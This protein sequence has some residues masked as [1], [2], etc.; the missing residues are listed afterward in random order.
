M[1][2]PL[3]SKTN[4]WT[5]IG[6]NIDLSKMI[7]YLI[8]LIVVLSGGIWWVIS[9]IN[10]NSITQYQVSILSQRMDK[11]EQ[12]GTEQKVILATYGEMLKH[13]QDD[14][15]DWRSSKGK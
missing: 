6:E 14:V 11:V 3:P 15:H 5:L 2:T 8:P 10:D 4:L 13:I 1:T 7:G 9:K 12:N